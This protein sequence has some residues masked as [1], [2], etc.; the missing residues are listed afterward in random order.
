MTAERAIL[1]KLFAGYDAGLYDLPLELLARR[2]AE[3]R[4]NDEL[5]ALPARYPKADP[6]AA[7]SRAVADLI[8]AAAKGDVPADYEKPFLAAQ[9][10]T[11]R[12]AAAQSI[13]A[14]A[15]A[16]LV[17]RTP[18]FAMRLSE[19]ILAEYLRPAMVAVLD[20]V[21]IGAELAP[22]V[23]WANERALVGA[24]QKVRDYY[25]VVSKANAD[26]I[27]L[28]AAQHQ[29]MNLSG[30]PSFEAYHRFGELRNMH[31]VWPQRD[32]GVESIRGRAPW[33]DGIERMVWLVTSKAEPWMPTGAEADAANAA[34]VARN[35]RNAVLVSGEQG[36][37]AATSGAGNDRTRR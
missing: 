34:L 18:W 5:R 7:R 22:R 6:A 14:E 16:E 9:E 8:E 17:D 1:S 20:R 4:V 30:T 35:S 15:K 12:L 13:L 21:A 27:G 25:E 19:E 33:P 31:A 36:F 28:R 29:L 23:P 32:S 3:V 11:R 24:D 2:E 37:V 26:Y 10:T